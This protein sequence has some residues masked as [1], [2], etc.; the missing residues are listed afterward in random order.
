MPL[1]S[2]QKS[3]KARAKRLAR[4]DA[5]L[6]FRAFP[7]Q[8]ASRRCP[9]VRPVKGAPVQVHHRF[10]VDL[11]DVDA[12]DD[13]LGKAMKVE[14]AI[15]TSYPPPTFRLAQ[16]APQRDLIPFKKVAAQTRLALLIPKRGGLQLLRELRMSD[17]AH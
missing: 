8:S 14:L 11:L 15:L 9:S 13:G 1:S 7:S 10:E 6:P 16:N 5:R 3:P 2:T 4:E 12:V 17:D